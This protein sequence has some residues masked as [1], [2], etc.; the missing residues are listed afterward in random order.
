MT[1]VLVLLTVSLSWAN[2][3]FAQSFAKHLIGPNSSVRPTPVDFDDDGDMDVLIAKPVGIVWLENNAGDFSTEHV[4]STDGSN[5]ALAGDVD[6]DGLV[7][8]VDYDGWEEI[9]WYQ[10][11]GNGNWAGPFLVELAGQYTAWSISLADLDGDSDADLLAGT[12]AEG[13]LY[14][15]ENVGGVF[16]TR[17]LLAETDESYG[18]QVAGAAD[19]DS[20]GDLDLYAGGIAGL[21][22]FENTGGLSFL[23][24]QLIIPG[25]VKSVS[26]KDMDLD[27]D[28]DLLVGVVGDA[29]GGGA[30]GTVLWIEQQEGGFPPAHI[31]AAAEI[32]P[33]ASAAVD[34]DLDGQL[35]IAMTSQYTCIFPYFWCGPGS[36]A[37]LADPGAIPVVVP[38]IVDSVDPV[39][40]HWVSAADLNDDG[41]PDLLVQHQFDVE[42]YEN[43]GVPDS[44]RD[45]LSDVDEV[46]FGTDPAQ[47]DSDCDGAL[48]GVEAFGGELDPLNPDTDGDG[49]LDGLDS[50]VCNPVEPCVLPDP[51]E[52]TDPTDSGEP[53]DTA[54]SSERLNERNS[55]LGGGGGCACDSRG[56]AGTG[57]LLFLLL[58]LGRRRA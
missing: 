45:G 13:A 22:W 18:A 34:T 54:A 26:V 32:Y 58:L 43:I 24:K 39:Y 6:G 37:V 57:G 28:P 53:P 50:S 9:N 5:G 3:A 35:E 42:W 41:R 36:L 15:Y 17:V 10:N 14:W 20:D 38:D 55:S 29:P 8:V 16:A 49:E 27:C 47:P 11:L 46:V 12:N 23:A 44:D 56:G 2:C 7:D 40:Y 52:T 4:I 51:T 48:D 1:R 33:T 19:L 25:N 30:A 21:F 31:L